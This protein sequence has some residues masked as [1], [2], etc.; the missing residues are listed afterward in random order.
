MNWN[1]KENQDLDT[2]FASLLWAIAILMQ[3]AKDIVRGMT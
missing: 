2:V 1:L 3:G